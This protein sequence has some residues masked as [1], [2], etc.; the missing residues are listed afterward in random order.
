VDEPPAV[1]VAGLEVM[2]TVGVGALVKVAPPHPAK[3]TGSES[4]DNIAIGERIRERSR[5]TRTWIMVFSFLVHASN[6]GPIARL[7]RNPTQSTYIPPR[8]SALCRI[9]EPDRSALLPD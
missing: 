3:T 2:L 4:E 9:G 1:I 8:G 6:N 5:E 7:K